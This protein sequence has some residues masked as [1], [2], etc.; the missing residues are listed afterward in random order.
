MTFEVIIKKDVEKKLRGLP[1]AYYAKIRRFLDILKF[2]A[3]PYKSF[4]IEYL[5]GTANISAYR[6]RIGVG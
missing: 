4:D 5:G 6:V 1:R 3:V 2:E